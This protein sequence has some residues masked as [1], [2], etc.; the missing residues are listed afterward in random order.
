M[1]SRLCAVTTLLIGEMYMANNSGPSTLP[2]GTPDVQMVGRDLRPKFVS[3]AF[4][5]WQIWYTFQNILRHNIINYKL[6]YI[7][8]CFLW[9][10]CLAMPY[11]CQTTTSC[12]QV[13]NHHLAKS[14]VH[15]HLY[16]QTNHSSKIPPA[17]KSITEWTVKHMLMTIVSGTCLVIISFLCKQDRNKN[18][19]IANRSR[20]SCAHNT[21]R[22]SIVTLWPWILGYK[23]FKVTET[24]TIWKLSCGFLFAFYSN[25]GTILYRL[26]DITVASYWS[27]ITKFLYPTCI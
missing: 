20:V 12:L 14:V 7:I 17:S 22:A 19:A 16:K 27:K 18:L 8:P 6:Y 24:G 15:V 2:C 13:G 4:D 9:I 3:L 1:W 10:K 21:S 26:R 5:S 11:T 23:S 25:Y